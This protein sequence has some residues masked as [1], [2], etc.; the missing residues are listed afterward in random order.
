MGVEYIAGAEVI[1]ELVEILRL[2]CSRAWLPG[3][4]TCS[5]ATKASNSS[6]PDLQVL[7]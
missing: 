4:K 6:A 1:R 3:P 2:A 5:K 7:G